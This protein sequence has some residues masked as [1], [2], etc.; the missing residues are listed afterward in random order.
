[1]QVQNVPVGA[2][3]SPP[4]YSS[5]PRVGLGTGVLILTA[6]YLC[7]VVQRVIAGTH[8]TQ[9]TGTCRQSKTTSDYILG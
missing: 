9:G 3:L 8:S 7:K 5:L 4:G 1:M 6:H 2:Q